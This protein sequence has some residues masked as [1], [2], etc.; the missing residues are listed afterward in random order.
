M[1][2][3]QTVRTIQVFPIGG[4]AAHDPLDRA[5]RYGDGLFETVLLHHGRPL[6]W[7]AHLA[8]LLHGAA[9]LGY[10]GAGLDWVAPL[11]AAIAALDP[12]G[13]QPWARLRLQVWRHAAGAYAPLDD[14]VAGLAE[15][16]PLPELPWQSSTQARLLLCPELGVAHSP[17]SALKSCSALVY[18]HAARQA[19]RAGFD[20]A[21]LLNACDGSVAEASAANFFMVRDQELWTPHL[22]SGCLPGTVRAEVLATAAE[23]GL[24]VQERRITIAD[25]A[26]ADEIFLTN[27]IRGL[28][29]VTS[30]EGAPLIER[31]HRLTDQLRD[32]VRA[33][34]GM[35]G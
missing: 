19:R 31:G 14:T 16:H 30:I 9:L 5:H 2:P 1:M 12:G 7:A 24:T 26:L 23:M 27:A 29:S 35:P 25:L 34:R 21:L 15:W 20:E 8:R 11:E 10:A 4:Q 28:V 13:T 6:G 17:L 18:V 3:S 33:R 22:A 32:R